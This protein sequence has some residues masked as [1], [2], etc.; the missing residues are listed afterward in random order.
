M[1]GNAEEP[2]DNLIQA[3]DEGAFYFIQKPF[4]RRV[5]LAL[6]NRCLEL[7]RLREEREKYLRRRGSTSS[8]RPAS[9]RSACCLHRTSNARA[10]RSTP[11]TSPAPSSP[12]TSTTMSQASDGAVALLDRR[13]GRPRDVGGDD[14]RGRQ[15]GVSSVPRRR[16]RTAGRGRA[17]QGRNIATSMRADSSPCVVPE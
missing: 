9:S 10:C 3:I 15:G 6:V 11:A 17:N 2:D 5:L 14:D 1:T 8:K 7:R 12:A 13:R 4:D 16:L